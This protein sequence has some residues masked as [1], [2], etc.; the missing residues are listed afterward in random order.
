MFLELDKKDSNTVAIIDSYNQQVSYGEIIDFAN[1][2]SKVCRN[3]A[4]IFILAKNDIGAVVGYLA[5]MCNGIVP[6]M[7][8]ES[9]DRE[10][11]DDL[12]EVYEPEYIWKSKSIIEAGENN[13]IEG[14]GYGLVKTGYGKVDMYQD[15]SLLLTTSGSTGS[16]KLVRHSYSNLEA[17]ARN[18]SSF[19]ELTHNDR[20]LL[21]L[22]I[23]YTYGLSVLNSHLYV[24]ATVLLTDKNLIEKGYWD[25]V[26]AQKA[27]SFTNVPYAYEILKK[28]RIERMNLPYLKMFSQGGGK[29]REELHIEFAEMCQRTNRKFV[30]TYGQTE[31]SARMAYLPWEYALSKVGSIG[32][33]IPNG[34]IYVIDEDGNPINTPEAVGEMVY[35]GPNVTLGYAT[36]KKDL[37]K[38]DEN[39]GKLITGD[40]VKRDEDGFL[41][42]IGRK[43]RFVKLNGMR[44]GLDECERIISSAFDIEC[45][46]TGDDHCMKIYIVAA[47][48]NWQLSDKVLTYIS[49]KTGI[50]THYLKVFCVDKLIRNEAGKILYSSFEDLNI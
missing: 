19:F 26:K 43:K 46:C 44:I 6:L 38:G 24:G 25:F 2:F 16:P 23:N 31:G 34:R 49:G 20:P 32:K 45:A 27:T 8:G 42:I 40:I 48:D 17:Q 39:F 22:P 33:A 1:R 4:L 21:D 3:R 13:I 11:L 18:I 10:L 14:F 9:M 41:F 12:I 29:L 36:S 50:N 47:A 15:L 30:V 5:A 7:L 28:L 37:T 35:E